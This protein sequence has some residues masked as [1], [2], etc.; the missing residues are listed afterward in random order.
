MVT[1]TQTLVSLSRNEG[2]AV[3]QF[4]LRIRDA[5]GNK[6]ERAALFGSKA[7]GDWSDYSDI[8]I[9]LIVTDADWKFHKAIIGI[10]SDVSLE[11]D[12]LL[13]VHIMSASH[14]QYLK[15]IQAGYYQNIKQDSVPLE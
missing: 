4:L 14:W 11:Y 5:Y 12:L 1:P 3:Q 15:D 8:D 6:I 9:L 13:D 10:G 2:N 7:R